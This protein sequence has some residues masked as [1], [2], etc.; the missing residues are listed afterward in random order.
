MGPRKLLFYTHALVGG[1]AERVWA[2]LAS[3][4]AARGDEVTFAVDFEA[5]ESLAMLSSGVSLQILPRGHLQSTLALARLIRRQKPDASLSA[6][7]VSNL[8]HAIAAQLARRGGRAILSYHGFFDSEP[9]LLS[10]IGYRLTPLLTR[11]SA[12]TVAVSDSLRDDLVANFGAA[13]ARTTTIFNPAAPEPFPALLDANALAERPPLVVAIGR[14]VADKDFVALLRAFAR[15]KRPCARLMIL[16]EG[17][18]RSRLQA[19]AIA[20]GIAQ[21]VDMPGFSRDPGKALA[22]ARCF[23]LTSL[24]ES[25]SLVCV[26]A[27]AYGLPVV[28]TDCGGPREIVCDSTL[29]NLAPVGDVEGLAQAIDSAL[30][31]PGDPAPRQR[32][33]GDFTLEKALDRYDKLIDAVIRH[34]PAPA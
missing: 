9:E 5:R 4:F 15:I 29:G 21:R 7:S 17:A 30:A 19:E 31:D 11:L 23:A 13:S 3:G 8:K 14:L 24:R 26:E 32:R 22:G 20:L 33:A 27:L 25:F 16:G 10:R 28:A 2:R 18:E 6:I 12:A 1:G 34:R